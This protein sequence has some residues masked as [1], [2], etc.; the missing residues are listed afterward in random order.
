MY[1][2]DKLK[3][4]NCFLQIKTAIFSLNSLD[5]VECKALETMR[6]YSAILLYQ[7]H[8]VTLTT[9]LLMRACAQTWIWTPLP[10]Q[11]N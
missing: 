4:S 2:T 3:F 5:A 6:K 9:H 8:V 7:C 10:T 1:Y 11:Q